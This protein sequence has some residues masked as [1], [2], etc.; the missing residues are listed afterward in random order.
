[1]HNSKTYG[2]IRPVSICESSLMKPTLCLDYG[3]K[4]IGVAVATTP[5][6]EPLGIIPNSKNPRLTDIVTDQA[7]AAILKL[8]TEFSIE[9]LV[10]GVSE[11]DMADKTRLFIEKLQE[12]T[13]LPIDEV[14]ETLSSVSASNSMQ[15]MHKKKREGNRDHIAAAIMLQEYMD[16]HL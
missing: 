7:I 8:I 3:V 13:E 14:N 10:V 15:H 12:K 4:R 5:L 2:K 6:A 1:M 9:Q 16:L 11:G